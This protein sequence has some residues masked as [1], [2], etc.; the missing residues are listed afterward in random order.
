MSVQ[1]RR[2][3][4]VKIFLQKEATDANGN[5][6]WAPDLTD[7]YDVVAHFTPNR[8]SRAEVNGQLEIDVYDMR[9]DPYTAKHQGL[10]VSIADI[11]GIW[12]RLEWRGALWDIVTPP[13]RREGNHRRLRHWTWE[14]RKRASSG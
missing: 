11:A 7:P 8:G 4:P 1:R 3:E 12:S 6:Q 9:F 10:K 2:G 14:I 5:T 13:Q